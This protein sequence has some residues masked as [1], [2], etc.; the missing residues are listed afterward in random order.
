LTLPLE[1]QPFPSNTEREFSMS[2]IVI[3]YHSGYGHTQRVAEMVAQGSGGT[4]LAIDAEG[5]LPAGGWEMLAAARAIV[6]GSPTYMGS[7]SWQF[8]KFADASSKPWFG[9]GWKNKLA[10]GFTNSASLNG[11]KH[12]TLH[13]FITLSQ[14]HSMLWVGTGMMPVNH[15]AAQRE[16]INHLGSF[17]GLMTQSP[18]DAAPDEMS[19]GDLATAK[20]FGQRIVEALALM[21]G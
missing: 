4:L 21:K 17:A 20:A 12:S 10:A 7:V 1:F 5:N 3:V 16:D 13:Y 19:S 11:D 18:S 8:K 6:F 15:K 14:Q 2:N 9:Q